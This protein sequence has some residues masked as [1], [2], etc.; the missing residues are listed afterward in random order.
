MCEANIV[1]VTARCKVIVNGLYG[2]EDALGP[3]EI[4][5]TC[6]TTESHCVSAESGS[7]ARV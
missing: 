4:L 5:D 2:T 1:G 6:E 3:S 7:M